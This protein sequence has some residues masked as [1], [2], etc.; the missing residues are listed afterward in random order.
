MP[1]KEL[2]TPVEV[3]RTITSWAWDFGDGSSSTLQ[4]P[5]HTFNSNGSYTISLTV[6]NGL[7]QD[8]ETKTAYI[9]VGPQGTGENTLSQQLSLYPVPATTEMQ[10]ESPEIIGQLI[11][12]DM[13]GTEVF[14][15][16]V[17]DY[18]YKLSVENLKQGIYF[19]KI[20]TARGSAV[21]KFAVK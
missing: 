4:N 12:T 10:I 7:A 14:R 21:K 8:T 20:D 1:A 2:T 5:T 9:Q 18:R 11:I 15:T 6:S 17:D 13:T 3:E 16:R 19:L